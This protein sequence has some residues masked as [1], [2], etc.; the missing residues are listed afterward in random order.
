MCLRGVEMSTIVEN[1]IRGVSE[2]PCLV[3]M[4]TTPLAP[5]EP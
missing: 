1:S 5:I 3:V 4:S 2:V